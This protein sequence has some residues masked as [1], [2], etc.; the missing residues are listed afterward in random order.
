MTAEHAVGLVV[1]LAV[2][3]AGL[4]A[5]AALGE[6]EASID[7]DR[8]ALAMERRPATARGGVTVHELRRPT[9]SVREFV[10]PAGTVFA[11]AWSG[12]APPDLPTLLGAYYGEYRAAAARRAPRGPRRVETA[13]VIVETW[14]HGRALHGRA[15]L[16]ALVPSGANVD[17]VQ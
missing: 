12:G 8:R 5:R 3:G 11:V 14:G 7:R 2:L 16:P 13:N 4:P 10:D 17:D 15:W 6:P 9:Q 1:A